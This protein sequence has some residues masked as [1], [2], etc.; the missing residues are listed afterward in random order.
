MGLSKKA[1]ASKLSAI[2]EMA[3][4]SASQGEE[5][6]RGA[7]ESSVTP[8]S[9]EPDGGS[10]DQ[11]KFCGGNKFEIERVVALTHCHGLRVPQGERGVVYHVRTRPP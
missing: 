10:D 5:R 7:Q 11:G 3:M 2:E 6:R 8:E 4:S 1:V 9:R